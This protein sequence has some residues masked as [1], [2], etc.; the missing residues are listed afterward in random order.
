MVT[1]R[2]FKIK[3]TL[4]L[5]E[6]KQL[7]LDTLEEN[8][9]SMVNLIEFEPNDKK[10]R[11]EVICLIS[12]NIRQLSNQIQSADVTITC[13]ET[14]NTAFI[15]DSED[16]AVNVFIRFLKEMESASYSWSYLNY[17]RKRIFLKYGL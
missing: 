4:T 5:E 6:K 16:F 17:E 3:M 8:V 1:S 15:V 14:N 9:P 11:D 2:L 10:T 12:N 7:V 13:D